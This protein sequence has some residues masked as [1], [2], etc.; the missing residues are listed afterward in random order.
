M[1]DV[2]LTGMLLV[3]VA[4]GVV[5]FVAGLGAIAT[6]KGGPRHVRAG[7]AYV[8]GMGVVVVTAVPLALAD[9]DYFLLT[10]AIFSGYLVLTGYRV[11]ARKRPTPGDAAAIDWV[12][13]LTMVA[14]GVGMVTL[15]VYDLRA[16]ETLGTALVVFGGIGL[17]LAVREIWNI[18]RPPDGT[19]EWFFRH[20]VFMGG[21]YIATVTAAVTVN[22][23]MLPALVR[24]VGPTVLGTPAIVVAVFRYRRRF[25]RDG[26]VLAG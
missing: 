18:Y 21:A 23:T 6:E 25:Q 8:L 11:L 2:A 1:I 5:A 13:H 22:L 19:H 17:V 14:F 20:V 9:G 15:G 26:S 7:K 4:A 10:I 24:W 12:S 16:G 3:H